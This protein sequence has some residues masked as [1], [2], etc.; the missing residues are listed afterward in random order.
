MLA[1]ATTTA[2]HFDR[3]A[4][5]ACPTLVSDCGCPV[6]A[7]QFIQHLLTFQTAEE[8]ARK[9]GGTVAQQRA[10]RK[11][12]RRYTQAVSALNAAFHSAVK[13]IN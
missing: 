11:A 13:S 6:G 9:L 2:K 5:T 12:H 1:T 4:R 8:A 10:V 3:A 7:T